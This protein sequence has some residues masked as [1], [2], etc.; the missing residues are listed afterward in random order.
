MGTLV[1]GAV[2]APS[3]FGAPAHQSSHSVSTALAIKCTA[4]PGK[5]RD[6]PLPCAQIRAPI[7]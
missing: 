5:P 6:I 4:P 3:I 7:T 1:D 2:T